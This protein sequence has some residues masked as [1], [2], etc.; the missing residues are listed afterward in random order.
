MIPH[1]KL[2]YKVDFCAENRSPY[3]PLYSMPNAGVVL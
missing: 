1:I 2:T 3:Y